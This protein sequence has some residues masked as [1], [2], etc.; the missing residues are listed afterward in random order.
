MILN[1]LHIQI[2]KVELLHEADQPRAAEVAK[3]VAGQ[4]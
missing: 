3:G 4:P 2:R 1:V